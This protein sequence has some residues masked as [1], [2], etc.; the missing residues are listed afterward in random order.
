MVMNQNDEKVERGH[1]CS[2]SLLL[3][4]A[5]L[6]NL[7]ST[8]LNR[9]WLDQTKLDWKAKKQNWVWRSWGKPASWQRWA[10]RPTL[11]P[12]GP[13]SSPPWWTWAP[14]SDLIIFGEI[15]W[16]LIRFVEI[17][18]DVVSLGEPGNPAW[19]LEGG[20]A[21]QEKWTPGH[22]VNPLYGHIWSIPWE[23]KPQKDC[24]GT[25]I[26]MN[27]QQECKVFKIPACPKTWAQLIHLRERTQWL[28]QVENVCDVVFQPP[29]L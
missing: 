4:S 20:K 21:V 28:V 13:P 19:L 14:W 16:D 23:L 8:E 2:A 18:W 9:S 3:F 1:L 22:P 11:A 25:K 6:Q 5:L 24:H 12:A 27:C 15:W 10:S 29:K 7:N 26:V 17:W